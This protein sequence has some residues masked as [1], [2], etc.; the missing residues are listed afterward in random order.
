MKKMAIETMYKMNILLRFECR[1][2]KIRQFVN[3]TTK[4]DLILYFVIMLYKQIQ[5]EV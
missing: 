4:Y 3:C 2:I 5:L 1:I